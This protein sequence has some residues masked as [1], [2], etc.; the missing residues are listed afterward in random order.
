MAKDDA[1]NKTKKNTKKGEKK[2]NI[3]SRFGK[4][5]KDTFAELKKVTWPTRKELAKYT[6]AVVVFVVIMAIVVG[7]MDFVL[8]E[9][10]NL[11][12]K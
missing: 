11:I 10:L 6:T 1:K 7:A 2:R 8:A 12:V 4:Y 3:F 9:G 5:C